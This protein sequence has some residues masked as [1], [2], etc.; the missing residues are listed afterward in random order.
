MLILLF[1]GVFTPLNEEEETLDKY[2]NFF[3]VI[4]IIEKEASVSR[5]KLDVYKF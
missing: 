4:N 5:I 3:S 1:D 2:S